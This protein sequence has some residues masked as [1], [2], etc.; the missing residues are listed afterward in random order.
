MKVP[1]ITTKRPE[2]SRSIPGQGEADHER[3]DR[4]QAQQDRAEAEEREQGEAGEDGAAG[5]ARSAC[6]GPARPSQAMAARAMAARM[7]IRFC[8]VTLCLFVSPGQLRPNRIRSRVVN[9][10]HAVRRFITG[11][12]RRGKQPEA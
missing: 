9:C 7:R 5:G 8:R 6:A 1:G 11:L 10:A 3:R 12:S 4:Q 2:T